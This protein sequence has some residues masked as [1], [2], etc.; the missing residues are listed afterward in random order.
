[1]FVGLSWGA[2][3]ACSFGAQFPE[4][5][6]AIVLVD[7]GYLEWRDVP[8]IDADASLE[9][10]IAAVEPESYAGWEEYLWAERAIRRRWTPAL[11]ASHRAMMRDV[12]GAIVSIIG[13]DVEG[14]IRYWGYQESVTET[15]PRLAG[16]PV[17]LLTAP[18]EPEFRAVSESALARFREALPLA[19]VES[20]DGG[21][22]LV[23]DCAPELAA[24]V[25]EWLAR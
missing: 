10:C 20:L 6:T 1:M 24:I 5:T 19:T 2:R 21:H 4:R 3:I 25:G 9:A 17:L 18:A 8:G 23:S 16:V 22:D 11:E 14:A 12:D 7:G 13:P 15:Y